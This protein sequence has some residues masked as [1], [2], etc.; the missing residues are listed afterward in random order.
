[1]VAVISF[2]WICVGKFV[3]HALDEKARGYFNLESLWSAESSATDTSDQVND[4]HF[5][6]RLTYRFCMAD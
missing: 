2:F 3:V 4:S 5:L 6:E 1:M